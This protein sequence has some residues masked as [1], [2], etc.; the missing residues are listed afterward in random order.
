MK[1][2]NPVEFI[3]HVLSTIILDAV[4]YFPDNKKKVQSEAHGLIFGMEKEKTVEC[5]YV[6]PVGSVQK[7]T[8]VSVNPDSKVD[9]AVKSA[10]ELFSTSNCI[11]TYHSHPYDEPFDGWADP[12]NGDCGSAD[13]LNLPYFIIVAIARNG[14]KETPLLV[15]Y[16]ECEGYEFSYNPNVDSHDF[17][18][19]NPTNQKV[20]YINGEFKK[21]TFTV[22]V[23][24]NTGKSLVDVDLL[25]S[26]AELMM[27]LDENNISLDSIPQEH[28]NSL[29]KMEYN[30]RYE[31]KDRSKRNLDYHLGSLIKKKCTGK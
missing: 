7:R 13:Y 23:Y 19:A 8:S 15:Q 14:I 11:G 10:K 25:S 18:D 24:K 31:N 29:R 6:F 16:S 26:E 3:Q 17:P 21:Y 30:M 1:N 9:E 12:S 28:T 22:R 5:D 20:T 4:Q 2:N 27:L